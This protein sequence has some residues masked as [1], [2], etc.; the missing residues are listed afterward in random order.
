MH[1][2]HFKIK[3][4]NQVHNKKMGPLPSQ[5]GMS[6]GCRWQRLPP[7]MKHSYK[8]RILNMQ[9]QTSYMGWSYSSGLGHEANNSSPSK[10]SML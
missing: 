5:H 3:Y 1:V 2:T 6:C 7:N 10:A 9:S 8:Y 4:D